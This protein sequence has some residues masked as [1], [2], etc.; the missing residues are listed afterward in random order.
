MAVQARSFTESYTVYTVLS[1]TGKSRVEFVPEFDS[2][3]FFYYSD[4]T[5]MGWI[6]S[7]LT[8]ESDKDLWLKELIELVAKQGESE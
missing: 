4:R 7:S 6:R 3:R 5:G 2:L 1:R 8:E